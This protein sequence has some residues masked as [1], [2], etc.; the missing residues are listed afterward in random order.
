MSVKIGEIQSA[1]R[2]VWGGCP[3]GSILGVFLFNATID[4]LEE[5]CEDITDEMDGVRELDLDLDTEEDEPIPVFD[6]AV[7]TPKKTNDPRLSWNDSPVLLPGSRKQKKKK[8]RRL[9][10]TDEIQQEVPH[11]LNARTEAK[12]TVTLAALLRYIDD[13]FS[14]TRV[15]FE[16]SFGMTVNGIFHRVKHT[17]QAQNVFRHL[18]RRAEEI[19]MVVNSSKTAMLCVSDAMAYEAD[20]FILDSDQ[21]RIGCQKSIKALGMH[22]S[23]R[24]DIHAVCEK[25]VSDALL[26]AEKF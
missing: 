16:N 20:A 18:V 5:G 3:Q 8:T 10:T 26:D 19:G 2:E 4:D 23:S 21:V 9:N 13:G 1:P 7:S 6:C 17:V 22:F 12:W 24:P 25:K 11:E 14:I 15:N